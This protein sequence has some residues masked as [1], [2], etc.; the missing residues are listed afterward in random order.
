LNEAIADFSRAIK[1]KPDLAAAYFNR[2]NARY[3]LGELN[4]AIADYNRAIKIKP[5][6]AA[7]YF[8]RGIARMILGDKQGAIE[9]MQKAVQLF[10]A[11]GSPRCQLAQEMLRKLQQ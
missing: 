8:N 10:C 6:Y 11:Q 4:E 3:K 9:D 1:I 2:G 7:A 5:D